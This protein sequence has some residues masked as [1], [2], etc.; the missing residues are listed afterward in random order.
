M[1]KQKREE[2]FAEKFRS[3]GFPEATIT[4]LLNEFRQQSIAQYEEVKKYAEE[5][6]VQSPK[7]SL[8]E[9]FESQNAGD[10][11]YV[12]STNAHNEAMEDLIKHIDSKIKE[13]N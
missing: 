4:A 3:Q 7:Y 6:K 13:R 10:V 11:E 12:S 1:N 5:N 8:E 9:A 2:A